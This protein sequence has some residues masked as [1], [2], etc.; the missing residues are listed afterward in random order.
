M[1][2]L[3][4]DLCIYDMFFHSGIRSAGKII[5]R[6]IRKRNNQGILYIAQGS[7]MFTQS[8]KEPLVALPN[9]IVI[10]PEE[11]NYTM[12]YIG[13]S[14]QFYL[15]NFKMVTPDGKVANL[16]RDIEII[17]HGL[18]PVYLT[19]LFTKIANSCK[20]EKN[21]S[22]FKRKE[23]L[24][25]FIAELF[26]N[27]TLSF[28]PSIPKYAVISR[29]IQM[30]QELYLENI[31]VEELAAAC[32]IS[33]SSF[34]QLF[35]EYYGL[36]PIQ[37]RSKLRLKRATSLLLDGELNVAE[38]AVASGFS[39]E[40]YFCRYYKKMTGETPSETRLKRG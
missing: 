37:Y 27:E 16:T 28:L 30:L 12:E 3:E 39:N 5:D 19:D 13:D 32:N 25:R 40:G 29:G 2:F 34:R 11:Q 33:V 31:S 23:Y 15:I 18:S 17:L 36:S 26:S 6:M 9:D 10:I 21:V 8:G 1:N 38:V 20:S 24:Y 35:T 4:H 14:T 7:V 22:F